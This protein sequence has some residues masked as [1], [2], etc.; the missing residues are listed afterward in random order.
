MIERML[1]AFFRHAIL[2]VLP[3]VLI[4]MDAAAAALSTPPQYEATAG[5]WVERA[6]YLTYSQDDNIYLSPAQNQRNRLAEL[7]RS[8]TFVAGVASRTALAPLAG[9]EAGLRQ[10]D[11]IFTRDFDAATDGDHL[12]VLRFRAEDRALALVSLRAVI[13]SFRDRVTSDLAGQGR[14][15]TEFYQARLTEAETRLSG[16]RGTLAGVV[17]SKPGLAATLAKNGIDAARLDP[18]FAEA[19]RKV[20]QA[21]NDADQARASLERA[22]LDVSASK[23][24]GDYGFRIAD[25]PVVS[26]NASRQLKKVLVYPAVGIFAAILV[27]AALLLFFTLSDHSIRSLATFAPDAVILGVMPHLRPK[28]GGRR[29]GAAAT[30]RAI[31][32]LAG[33]VLP[34]QKGWRQRS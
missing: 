9:S 12:L 4:P 24:G 1:E 25:A 20:D 22:Q 18:Q 26:A 11:Q 27:S 10:L 6:T 3:L 7:L 13:D 2:I 15:A 23:Q 21:Q 34:L 29:A 8:R 16:A 17:D 28:G 30:R 19:Q 14:L 33:G 5:I 32:Y 31:A